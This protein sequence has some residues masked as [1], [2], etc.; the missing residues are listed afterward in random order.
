[1]IRNDYS[2]R[3]LLSKPGADLRALYDKDTGEKYL[4]K[5]QTDG[6]L[7][8]LMKASRQTAATTTN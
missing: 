6:S 8:T 1:V 7:V 4:L 2:I 5:Y 3:V